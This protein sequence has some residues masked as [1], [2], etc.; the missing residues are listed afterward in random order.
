[1]VMARATSMKIALSA[2]RIAVRVAA[3]VTAAHPTTQQVAMIQQSQIASARRTSTVAKPNGT[4]SVLAKS[5]LRAAA[6]V[7]VADRSAATASAEQARIVTTAPTIVAPVAALEAVAKFRKLKAATTPLSRLAS[8]RRIPSAVS[9]RGT[10]SAS[11]KWLNSAAGAARVAV[12]EMV[13]VATMRVACHAP[14]TVASASVL[15][16][17]PPT[18]S[19]AAK[20]RR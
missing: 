16:A 5:N 8:V 14:R 18:P 20:S 15:T 1:M 4:T 13:N 10:V 9:L 11:T 19:L 17:A 3:M 12:A 2:P 6:V 7:K